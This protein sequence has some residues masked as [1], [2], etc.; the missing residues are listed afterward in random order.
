MVTVLQHQPGQNCVILLEVITFDGY[1]GYRADPEN[2][3]QITRIFFPNLSL[4]SGFPRDMTKLNTGLYYFNFTL[5]SNA[6]SIGTYIVD[7]SWQD[8]IT[9]GT[10]TQLYQI[11]VTAPYGQYS[12]SVGG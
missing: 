5:P 11:V 12:A 6:S 4:A 7:V 9:S 8:P 10:K 3:P 2:L 1:D